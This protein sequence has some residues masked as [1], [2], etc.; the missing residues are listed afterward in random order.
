MPTIS[1]V[2]TTEAPIEDV[3]AYL[4]DFSNAPEWDP[5]TASSTP[6]DGGPPHVG[7]VYDLV[8]TW[9]SRSLD[10]QYE[11]VELEAPRLIKLVGEGSTTKAIDTMT[12]TEPADGG[13]AVHY[14]ADIRLKGLLR[15]VEPLLGKKFDAL[16]DEA[17]AG[18][19]RE[20]AAL[21]D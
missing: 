12:L 18:M 17:E 20:L 16:G 2:I 13:T 1:R 8:V 5:G 7:E 4:A 10:M 6:R 9:G 3:F 19:A 11:I 14:E 15:F 21:A